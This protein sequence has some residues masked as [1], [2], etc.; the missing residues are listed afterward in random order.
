MALGGLRWVALGGSSRGGT[1][2]GGNKAGTRDARRMKLACYLLRCSIGRPTDAAGWVP[3]GPKKRR[4]C[5]GPPLYDPHAPLPYWKRPV[6]PPL[7]VYVRHIASR[8]RALGGG[9]AAPRPPY[10]GMRPARNVQGALMGWWAPRP[11]WM[12][13]ADYVA[14]IEKAMKPDWTHR[15][16]Q[17]FFFQV[18]GGLQLRVNRAV[19]APREAR[20]FKTAT[21]GGGRGE[22]TN[23]AVIPEAR[24]LVLL[25]P[26]AD[27]RQCC[28]RCGRW[29]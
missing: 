26:E 18:V 15:P 23:L 28:R 19:P 11:T 25:D 7:P 14:A 1:V 6:G 3:W 10:P 2:G 13:W 16:W 12:A 4:N 29:L 5:V 8:M 20:C 17:P 24:N 27:E 21:P 22:A 9:H